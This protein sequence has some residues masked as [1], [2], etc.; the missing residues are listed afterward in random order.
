MKNL[1]RDWLQQPEPTK[2]FEKI[3]NNDSKHY[4]RKYKTKP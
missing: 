1:K 4:H 3:G 2:Y